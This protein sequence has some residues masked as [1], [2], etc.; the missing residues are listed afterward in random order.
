[1]AMRILIASDIHYCQEEYGGITRDE[2]LERLMAQIEAEHAREPFAMTLMLGD[3]SLDHWGW[4]AK[5][6]WPLRGKSF[7]ADF[8]ARCRD[9]IPAPLYM[10]AGNHE[11]YGE[12]KWREITGGGRE[13]VVDTDEC[14]FILW[15][16]FGGDLDPDFHSD[17]TYTPPKVAAI[18]AAMDEHPNKPVVLCSHW[19][20]PCGSDEEKALICD[21]RV[22][23][24]FVGHSHSS[25]VITLPEEYGSK[26]MIQ[27]GGWGGINNE[28]TE[29]WGI[30]D[31][32]ILEDKLISRY[33]VA[34]HDLYHKG[35]PY[36]LLAHYRDGVEVKL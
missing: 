21:G 14:L 18:R 3:Y 16:S 2:K 17:G 36:S 1:M 33:L 25:K 29:A 5:G 27:A 32:Y 34:D 10:L 23:C 30:R 26:K 15:D 28:S 9:R 20:A 35:E 13:H 31:L 8:L 22:K 11:Q 24:L 7:T 12:E 4:H 19:F 6:S